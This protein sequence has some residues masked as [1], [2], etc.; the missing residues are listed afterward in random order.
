MCLQVGG[1][2]VGAKST[3]TTYFQQ[4]VF[5]RWNSLIFLLKTQGIPGG[6]VIKNLPSNA[7]DM[8]SIPGWGT[9]ISHAAKPAYL[10]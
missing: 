6:P 5:K 9:K 3:A 4:K 2:W 10:D 1:M 8:G 7:G